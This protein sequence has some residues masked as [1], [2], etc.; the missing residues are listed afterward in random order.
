MQ[1]AGHDDEQ[2]RKN[3]SRCCRTLSVGRTAGESAASRRTR[4]RPRRGYGAPQLRRRR[5]KGKGGSPRPIP[6]GIEGGGGRSGGRRRLRCSGTWSGR[7]GSRAPGTDSSSRGAPT[8]AR[9]RRAIPASAVLTGDH[10]D[11]C[12]S[13]CCCCGREKDRGTGDGG[14]EEGKRKARVAGGG[15][16]GLGIRRAEG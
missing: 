13:A 1:R 6:R 7:R 11:H 10:G 15:L 4:R 16:R 8:T 5:G 14:G 9:T 12:G 2:R 3:C